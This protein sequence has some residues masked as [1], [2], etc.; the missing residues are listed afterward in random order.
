[1]QRFCDLVTRGDAS[2]TARFRSPFKLK[3]H[4]NHGSISLTLQCYCYFASRSYDENIG[5]Y[6]MLST[7]REENSSHDFPCLFQRSCTNCMYILS[8]S[9]NPPLDESSKIGKTK[10]H[11][12]NIPLNYGSFFFFLFLCGSKLFIY[13]S[14]NG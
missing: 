2:L 10:V 6:N 13:N 14:I 9:S 1:M 8:P 7:N 3:S 5:R 12:L 11:I 4:R